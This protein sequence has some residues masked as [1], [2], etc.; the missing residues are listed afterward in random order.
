M[1]DK[2]GIIEFKP[3]YSF[4]DELRKGMNIEPRHS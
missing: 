1:Y 4:S 3:S 2:D